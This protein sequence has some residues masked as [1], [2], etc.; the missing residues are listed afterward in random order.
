MSSSQK[1]ESLL[2]DHTVTFDNTFIVV[3]TLHS[4]LKIQ[5]SRCCISV[6]HNHAAIK[7]KGNFNTIMLHKNSGIIDLEGNNNSVSVADRLHIGVVRSVGG[8]Q[9]NRLNSEELLGAVLTALPN[10]SQISEAALSRPL[11]SEDSFNQSEI[12][13]EDSIDYSHFY[14]R[15]F[16]ENPYLERINEPPEQN[17]GLPQPREQLYRDE[18]RRPPN[19]LDNLFRGFFTGSRNVLQEMMEEIAG[20]FS[21]HQNGGGR[22]IALED[23]GQSQQELGDENLAVVQV[24]AIERPID[25]V[26]PICHDDL[27]RGTPGSAYLDC[28][29]WFHKECIEEWIKRGRKSCPNCRHPTNTLFNVINTRVQ[30]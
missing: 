24:Q 5:A 28:L 29:D 4:L 22:M 14:N 20:G 18:E 13:D 9:N 3:D 26:C 25:D 15:R 10:V 1:F 8:S 21:G 17:P 19:A 2:D 12:I 6:R 23:A 30:Y 16:M 11:F 7:I 27:K